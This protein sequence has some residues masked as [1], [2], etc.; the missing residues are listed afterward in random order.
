MTDLFKKLNYKNQ[1]VILALNAPESF[2]HELNAMAERHAEL[3]D[4]SIYQMHTETFD[5]PSHLVILKRS[6]SFKFP[7]FPNELI[8][9]S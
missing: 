5:S 7:V 9:I 3:R 6:T 4:V 8:L 1:P 2:N